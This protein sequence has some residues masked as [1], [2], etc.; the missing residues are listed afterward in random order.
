LKSPLSKK[1]A[2]IILGISFLAVLI[3]GLIIN[4]SVNRQFQTYLSRIEQGREDQIVKI[5]VDIYREYDG[6]PEP[7]VRIRMGPGFFANF[8]Y[9]TDLYGKLTVIAGRGFFNR[10]PAGGSQKSRKIAVDGK[11]VGIAYFAS[12]PL[13][14]YLSRQN[15]MF[16]HTINRSI[17]LAIFLAGLISLLTAGLLARQISLPITE[18]NRIAKNM[19]MGNLESRVQKLPRDEL[20]E[21]G[22]SLNRLAERLRQVENLRKK[23]TA[24]VAH[25]L[26]TPLTTIRSH[27][28]GMIDRVIP[29]SPENLDSLLEEIL[30]LTALVE[31]LQKIALVDS[32]IHKFAIEPLELDKFLTE[33]VKKMQPLYNEKGVRLET[34]EFPALTLSSDR[35]ALGKICDNL[36]SNALKFT[37]A[38]QSV[39]VE[40]TRQDTSAIISVCD[41]GIGISAADLPFIFERFYRTDRSR[42][43]ESGGFGLGLAI[44][45]E[46][47]E[48]LGGT[49]AVTSAPGKGSVF[50]VK[51]P[52]DPPAQ[53]R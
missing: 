44:V 34:G 14:D 36:L 13:E 42:N 43:R 40:L 33:Q 27:L 53:R 35:D 6:W 52:L 7:P 8:R 5:L 30:R 26:R 11:P 51:L 15:E 29:A 12:N 25:D 38:G 49:V 4:L 10:P 31:D 22:N 47:V 17:V 46:L 20:G 23:M 41:R 39:R 48:A 37:P 28:E 24:D 18:M 45:K 2:L 16:R 19:T 50:K 21:L 3:S 1:I 9:A 32:A